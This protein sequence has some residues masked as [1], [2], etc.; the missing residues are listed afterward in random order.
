MSNKK[1]RLY[2]RLSE[3]IYKIIKSKYDGRLSSYLYNYVRNNEIDIENNYI[4][5]EIKKIELLIDEYSNTL[6]QYN[7]LE[8]I[9]NYNSAYTAIEVFI[10][11]FDYNYI[12]IPYNRKIERY[13]C[14]IN[15]DEK[16][17]L[18]LKMKEYKFSSFSTLVDSM[19]REKFI[20]E[21]IHNHVLI[22]SDRIIKKLELVPRRWNLFQLIDKTN[23]HT[24]MN[25]LIISW[26]KKINGSYNI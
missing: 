15:D 16:Y 9:Q 20:T 8:Y 18:K 4:I 26:S 1:D 2:L 11:S 13:S 19:I 24:K 22:Y 6:K 25:K 17:F 7:D 23:Y 12:P 14:S 5:N 10:E 3:D 21:A